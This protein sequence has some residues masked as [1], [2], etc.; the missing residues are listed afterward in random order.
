[1]A[2]NQCHQLTADIASPFLFY[3]RGDFLLVFV[4]RFGRRGDRH[5]EAVAVEPVF[6]GHDGRDRGLVNRT[7]QPAIFSVEHRIEFG[8]VLRH[9]FVIALSAAGRLAGSPLVGGRRW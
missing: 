5:P 4:E 1:M 7:Y 8:T 9:K 2:V 6:D 3:T